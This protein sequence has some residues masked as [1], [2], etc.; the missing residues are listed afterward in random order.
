MQS[1]NMLP[2]S[3]V[4]NEWDNLRTMDLDLTTNRPQEVAQAFEKH[5]T[6]VRKML[7]RRRNP[8]HGDKEIS[9]AELTA[10]ET[11]QADDDKVKATLSVPADPWEN[12]SK[13]GKEDYLALNIQ[14]EGYLLGQLMARW[15]KKNKPEVCPDNV[16]IHKLLQR[17]MRD[18]YPLTI[19]A[20]KIEEKAAGDD[21]EIKLSIP[22]K[23]F[24]LETIVDIRNGVRLLPVNKAKNFTP[25]VYRRMKGHIEQVAQS[26]RG[27]QVTQADGFLVWSEAASG[28][29]VFADPPNVSERK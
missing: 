12:R 16:S 1:V 28:S 5:G 13:F 27:M 24:S 11:D 14:V 7:Y 3:A 20:E 29:S 23:K 15:D 10:W 25:S 17:N 18:K 8:E 22:Y 6:E 4:W 19:E 9:A 2:A 26:M 21:E